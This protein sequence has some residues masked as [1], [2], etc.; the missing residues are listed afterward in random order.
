MQTGSPTRRQF[1]RGVLTISAY[2]MAQGFTGQKTAR[3]EASSTDDSQASPP[4]DGKASS[5][6]VSRTIIGL[7]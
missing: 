6:N 7:I 3:A 1:L 5:A 4:D 2:L